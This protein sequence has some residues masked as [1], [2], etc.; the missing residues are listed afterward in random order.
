MSSAAP[1]FTPARPLA[2]TDGLGAL[3]ALAGAFVLAE[4]VWGAAAGAA[5]GL[6][7]GFAAAAALGLRRVRS[8]GRALAGRER[9]AAASLRDSEARYRLLAEHA[10]DMIVLVRADRTRAYVSP[11][12]RAL[13]GYEPDE[14]RGTDFARFVHPEDRARVEASYAAFCSAGGRT[15]SIYRLGH[16]D[17]SYRWIEATWVTIAGDDA[18]GTEVVSIVRDISERK[19]AEERIAFLSRHDPLTG[20]ANRVLLRERVEE[21]LR[22]AERGGALALLSLDLDRFQA[23]NDELGHAAGDALLRA[24]AHRLAGAVREADTVARLDGDGFA[25]LQAS[26]ERPEDAGRLADR[27]LASLAAP[28]QIEDR[29]VSLLASAGIAVAPADGAGFEGLLQKSEAALLRCKHEGRGA[30]RF[31]EPGMEARRRMVQTL[32]LDLRKALAAAEFELFYQAQVALGD[33]RITGVEALLRWRHPV[34]GL[35]SPSEFI[36]VAEDSGLIVPIGAWVLRQACHQAARWPDDIVIAVNLSAV[37]IRSPALLGT[38][39]AALEASGLPASRLELEITESVL[40]DEAEPTLAALRGLREMGVRIAMDDFGTG[41]SSL[42]YLRS[43]PWDKIKL[44]QSFVRDLSAVPDSTAIV[45][46]VAGLG[47][48]MGI[49][50]LAEGVENAEQLDRLRAAGYGEAQGYFF[51]RPGPASAFTDLLA[52]DRAIAPPRRAVAAA[53]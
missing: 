52:A 39:R 11:S 44:D 7:T 22:F 42:H 19:A 26:I 38:V 18:A 6:S 15:N 40:L 28:F 21:A 33:G 36:P 10:G 35:V 20:L 45:R 12:C 4:P 51:N 24:A 1:P 47:R 5:L 14:L 16:R 32:T 8:A 29:Q 53:S 17:G 25:V 13:L 27:L 41:Y 34:R 3:A 49:A 2:P 23:V 9:E 37:Q 46:A 50:T 30:W 43:F 48:S 31:F